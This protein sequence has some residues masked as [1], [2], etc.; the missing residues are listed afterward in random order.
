MRILYMR[1]QE[2]HREHLKYYMDESFER[3]NEE[4]HSKRMDERNRDLTRVISSGLD[5]GN[6]NGIISLNLIYTCFIIN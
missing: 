2:T 5:I 3:K 1:N 6:L 4:T